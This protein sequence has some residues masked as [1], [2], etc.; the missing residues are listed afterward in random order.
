MQ[1]ELKRQ[2]WI[3]LERLFVVF[4][5][6]HCLGVIGAQSPTELTPLKANKFVKKLPAYVGFGYSGLAF[7]SNRLYASC[8]IGLLEITNGT[9]SKVYQWN[10]ADSVVDGPW[11]DFAHGKLWIWRVG[12]DCL[13]FFDGNTWKSTAMPQPKHGYVT[14]GD[15]LSGCRGVSDSN[16]FWLDW[17]GNAWSWNNSRKKWEEPIDLTIFTNGNRSGTLE[18][19]FLASD[20]PF[21]AVR[22]EP[23][24]EI[25]GR[26]HNQNLVGDT[27]HYFDKG[28]QRIPD[29]SKKSFFTEQMVSVGGRGFARTIDGEILQIDPSGVSQIES[30]GF[31]EVLAVTSADTLLAS[32][33]DAGIYEF[34]NKWQLRFKAPY[35]SNEGE[36]WVHLAESDGQIALATDPVPQLRDGKTIFTSTAGLWFFDGKELVK[37]KF[38]ITSSNKTISNESHP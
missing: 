21:I 23:G 28:W 38:P 24:W 31:C 3:G 13:G 22:Y 8:N 10:K 19:M 36:K 34:V 9:V 32:F 14:R 27:F 4:L 16:S 35:P 15:V 26:E 12:D 2:H 11:L 5:T 17:V 25:L 1:A 29:N 20:K 33:R 6:I 30:P 37:I 18:R 7:Y